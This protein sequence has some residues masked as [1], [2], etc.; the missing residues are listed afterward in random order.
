MQRKTILLV[1][2]PLGQLDRFI[3]QMKQRKL[4]IIILETSAFIEQHLRARTDIDQ[5]IEVTQKDLPAMIA[6]LETN[7]S[8]PQIDYIITYSESTVEATAAL[9]QYLSLPWDRLESIKTIKDEFLCC[10]VLQT[11]DLAQPE[12]AACAKLK[13]VE[14][15]IIQANSSGPWSIKP[16][17]VTNNEG[18]SLIKTKQAIPQALERLAIVDDPSFLIEEFVQGKQYSIE[19]LL[20]GKKPQ[21]FALTKK[22][23]MNNDLFLEC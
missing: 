9:A 7:P 6:W 16:R 15:F 22:R 17:T 21:F 19:G 8:L 4:R 18:V 12:L 13:E 3:N 10:K 11:A 14:N 5:F 20:V 23:L 2:A 1:G